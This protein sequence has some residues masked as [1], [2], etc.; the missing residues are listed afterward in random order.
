MQS[1]GMPM[2]TNNIIVVG[3]SAGGLM[4]LKVFIQSL[5]IN[6]QSSFIIIQHRDPSRKSNLVQILA[7]CTDLPVEEAEDGSVPEP[8]HILVCPPGERP[9]LAGRQIRLQLSEPG[10]AFRSPID[11]FLESL[12]SVGEQNTCAVILSGTGSD[13]TAGAR[14]IRKAGGVVIVQSPETA[15]F[16]EMP[17][18]II[19]AG[20][21]HAILPCD[22]IWSAIVSWCAPEVPVSVP[23]AS[24]AEEA[25]A[26]ESEP[27]RI[28]GDQEA[29][30]LLQYELR[31]ANE[32]LNMT[33][34]ELNAAN[35]ELTMS[36]EELKRLNQDVE[37]SNRE[38]K[39]LNLEHEALLANAED[40]FLYVDSDQ[41]IRKYNPAIARIFPLQ[42]SDVGCPLEQIAYHL[43][44]HEEML[45]DVELV[46]REGQK[47]ERESEV[48]E[49]RIYLKRIVP[50]WKAEG[51]MEGALLS[52]TDITKTKEL[53]KRIEFAMYSARMS[54]WN[55]DL[56]TDEL[57]IYS[58]GECILGYDSPLMA[59][60]SK[61]WM[62]RVHRSDRDEV[63]NSLDNHLNGLT[64]EWTCEHRFRDRSGEWQ[65]VLN[66]GIVRRRDEDGKP[67]FM[68]GTT[69]DIRTHKQIQIELIEAKKRAEN[70]NRA[71]SDFLAVMSHELRTPLNPILGFSEMLLEEIDNPEHLDILKMITGAAE[72]LIRLIDEILDFTQIE[73]GR[74]Q[75]F[76][77]RINISHLVREELEFMSKQSRG[78]EI[79]FLSEVDLGPFQDNSSNLCGDVVKI[80]RILRN[81]LGNA[82]KFTDTGSITLRCRLAKTGGGL[83][84][85]VFEVEDT[86]EGISAT[87]IQRLFQPFSQIDT[88]S[89]RKH[90]GTGM[91]LAICRRLAEF[92]GGE[93]F[94]QSEVGRGSLFSLQ[95]NLGRKEEEQLLTIE[96]DVCGIDVE[97]DESEL[98]GNLPGTILLVEDHEP[99]LLYSRRIFESLGC[100]VDLAK[101][102]EE[103]LV[104]FDP[105][106]HEV[107]FL[108]LHM[109][110][111]GGLE[112]LR[113]IRERERLS[114]NPSMPVVIVTADVSDKVRE[115]C[116][117][118]GATD[119]L[120]KPVL[121]QTMQQALRNIFNV[122]GLIQ[123]N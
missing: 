59:T 10:R 57:M 51:E 108:D 64:K 37:L 117:E 68:M 21:A 28:Q 112:V 115:S 23:I 66:Q 87:D 43:R 104:L 39:A 116:L 34:E 56:P 5:P 31:S 122:K 16:P 44:G 1:L 25:E 84:K 103:A 42:P 62:R 98:D 24:G 12:A 67:L 77:E 88:T 73:E 105:H 123:A 99:T 102:G 86:G 41:I 93:I 111:I 26:S 2:E 27:A 9:V 121:P 91:G 19:T 53:E 33:I 114:G 45:R 15:K 49:G 106:R 69:Q 101:C 95:L 89:T 18:S 97:Q 46:L 13:G 4:P 14:A 96:K 83:V 40:G 119:F 6:S 90:G 75:L 50:F 47:V 54:W 65:W 60:R 107:V 52:F 72:E 80:R 11:S 76:C 120:T 58:A 109:P 70:A 92:L 30:R 32:E 74:V 8:N 38:L 20:L 22:E 3:A 63:R 36:N 85:T 79:E 82:I 35:E 81:L 48:L 78:K 100:Q 29:V 55:W 71:K 118:C 7:A 17:Q 94:V 61:G 110:G 113:T